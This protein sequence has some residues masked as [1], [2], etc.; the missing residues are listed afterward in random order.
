MGNWLDTEKERAD[1][2]VKALESR[3]SFRFAQLELEMR[4]DRIDQLADGSLVIIDYKTAKKSEIHRWWG[5]RPEEPQLPLYHMLLGKNDDVGG[6]AFATVHIEGNQLRGVGDENSP[7]TQI[8]FIDKYK[9]GAAVE[10]WHQLQSKWQ[11]V[12]TTL[13]EEFIAGTATV[14]PKHKTSTCTYC[15]FT[16]VCR[17]N[18][19]P[20][21]ALFDASH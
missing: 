2:S 8:R 9:S 19:P 20:L 17:I 14:D 11:Q 4:I 10:D 1:F 7:E 5:T 18:N 15:D 6:I 16:S 3:H 12:L 21:D 13:A